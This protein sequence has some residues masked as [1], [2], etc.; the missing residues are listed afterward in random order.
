VLKGR[1]QVA[2]NA[3]IARQFTRWT[4]SAGKHFPGLLNRRNREV[5]QF[6]EGFER[7]VTARTADDD[8]SLDIR[9]GEQAPQ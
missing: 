7:P 9:V 4:R 1:D 5:D 3:E 2:D 6:F 8:D